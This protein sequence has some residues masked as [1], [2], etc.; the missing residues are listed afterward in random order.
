MERFLKV[1]GMFKE[2]EM[3]VIVIPLIVPFNLL[4]MVNRNRVQTFTCG[5][6]DLME[7]LKR[8]A[9]ISSIPFAVLGVIPQ[10]VPVRVTLDQ[11]PR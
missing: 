3:N 9:S 10:E 11:V 4:N 7:L 6:V 5:E 8:C 2:W 1:S